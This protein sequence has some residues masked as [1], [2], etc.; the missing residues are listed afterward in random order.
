MEQQLKTL[1]ERNQALLLNLQQG[2]Q[3]CYDMIRSLKSEN[4]EVDLMS[5]SRLFN[6]NLQPKTMNVRIVPPSFEVSNA[7]KIMNCKKK[8][9]PQGI[10]ESTKTENKSFESLTETGKQFNAK[11]NS[12]Y[13]PVRDRAGTPKSILKRRKIVDDH[14]KV[15]SKYEHTPPYKSS[16]ENKHLNFSY[17][18]VD[19]L[20]T[21]KAQYLSKENGLETGGNSCANISLDGS[22]LDKPF[23]DKTVPTTEQPMPKA[24]DSI[25]TLLRERLLLDSG[26]NRKNADVVEALKKRPKSILFDET[27]KETKQTKVRSFCNQERVFV[28]ESF[29]KKKTKN[30]LQHY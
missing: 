13:S 12:S 27:Q 15:T 18:D 22:Y 1:R 21:A 4:G 14:I 29:T 28:C 26:N 24:V 20:E 8:R 25:D 5:S 10:D 11:E 6:E 7:R 2:Q 30:K 23:R 17:S 9:L 19:D 3:D 16:I